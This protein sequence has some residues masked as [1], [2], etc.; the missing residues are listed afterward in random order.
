M[1]RSILI[2]LMVIGGF[3]LIAAQTRRADA[4]PT[5]G[6]VAQG[7][8]VNK[9]AGEATFTVT[10]NQA[11][12]FVAADNGQPVAF[13]YEIDADS[14]NLSRSIQWSDVDTV[15]RGA[16]ISAGQGIPV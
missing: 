14:A 9:S 8:V 3:A 5:F 10:F 6:I 7:V 16:E 15:I 11:P 12:D 13:Q 2:G 1:R 4:E